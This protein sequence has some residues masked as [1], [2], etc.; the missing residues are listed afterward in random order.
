[1]KNYLGFILTH[2][3]LAEELKQSAQK[4]MPLYFPIFAFS[5]KIL[6]MENILLEMEKQFAQYNPERVV[7]FVDLL[8]GS[9]WHAAMNFKKKYPQVA[10]ITG[11]NIPSLISFNTNFERLDWADLL[12]KVEEDSKK[13]IKVL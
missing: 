8:G 2:G 12:Q 7:L 6:T 13:A 5:N 1:M 9:C 11:V 3:D 4:L 10:V